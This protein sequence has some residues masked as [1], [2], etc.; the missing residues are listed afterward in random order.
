MSSAN[1]TDFDDQ[2]SAY[3]PRGPVAQANSAQIAITLA[4]TNYASPSLVA[5]T[6]LLWVKGGLHSDT[7]TFVRDAANTANPTQATGTAQSVHEMPGDIMERIRITAAEPYVCVKYT[8][9][10]ATVQLSRCGE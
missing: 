5:G 1:P 4:N 8:S 6:Y 3:A 2:R 7:L 10:G 9:A